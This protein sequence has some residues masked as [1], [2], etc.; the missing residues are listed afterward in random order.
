MI[1]LKMNRPRGCELSACVISLQQGLHEV[2]IHRGIAL[3][4]GVIDIMREISRVVKPQHVAM[5]HGRA[6]TPE[7]THRAVGHSDLPNQLLAV[8]TIDHRDVADVR[9]LTWQS[10][11]RL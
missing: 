4:N 11:N 9:E 8:T 2:P 6:P 10:T 1:G 5:L 3:A 7:L